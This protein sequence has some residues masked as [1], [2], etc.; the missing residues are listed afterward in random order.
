MR[1]KT[2]DRAKE[3][4]RLRLRRPL[5]GVRAESWSTPHHL[6]AD[7]VQRCARVQ[8]AARELHQPLPVAPLQDG[9]LVQALW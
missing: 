7:A 3:Q 6:H 5:G 2:V 1:S 9:P 8:H 4:A